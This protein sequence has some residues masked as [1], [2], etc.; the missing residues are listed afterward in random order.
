M[1][2]FILVL[3]LC[4]LCT[5]VYADFQGNIPDEQTASYL[6][7]VLPAVVPQGTPVTSIGSLCANYLA[8]IMNYDY[9]TYYDVNQGIVDM[10]WDYYYHP[11]YAFTRGT[12]ICSTYG[13]ALAM[14]VHN[15]PVN[16]ATGLVD[17]T[18]PAPA[19]LAAAMART[20]DHAFT[21]I[22]MFNEWHLYD[23]CWYDGNGGWRNAAYLDIHDPNIL[24]HPYW[25]NWYF[26]Q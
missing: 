9:A 15:T 4:L 25:A 20:N 8:D 23:A 24:S 13:G 3:L 17:Y 7:T 5:P 11:E 12:G 21:V 22:N 1:K 6:Q 2:K 26:A 14:M 10:G 18:T 16:P 19:Y